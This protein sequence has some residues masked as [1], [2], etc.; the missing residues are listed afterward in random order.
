MQTVELSNL[1]SVLGVLTALIAPALLISANASFVLST[2]TR[3]ANN[4]ARA[5]ALADRLRR[6]RNSAA[7]VGAQERQRLELEL[8]V[9][10]RRVRLEQQALELFYAAT[11][12]FVACSLVLGVEALTRSLPYWWPVALGLFGVALQ[13]AASALLIMD[14]RAMARLMRSEIAAMHLEVETAIHVGRRVEV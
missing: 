12:L 8:K 7:K 4:T 13:L 1:P 11:I 5:R 10:Y 6:P 2:S 3:L 9:T 14:V